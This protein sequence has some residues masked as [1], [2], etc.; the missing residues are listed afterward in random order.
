MEKVTRK[1]AVK[2]G[3]KFYYTGKE[4]KY[5]H[6]D[7]RRLS[8][9]RCLVCEREAGKSRAEYG[10]EWYRKNAKKTIERVKANNERNREK[11]LAYYSAYQKANLRK[12]VER[13]KE[14]MKTDQVFAVKERVRGLIRESLKKSG[15]EKKSRT[16]EILGC[17]TVFFKE[18]IEKQFT[19]GMN[20]ENMGK[21]HIDHIIPMAT[22]QSEEDVL[23]LNHYTNLRPLWASENLRKSDKREFLI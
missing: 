22:A 17:S 11:M 12:I 7:F 5:G 13:R 2:L 15:T 14:R 20:W 1:D 4:C 6:I 23:A 19:K 8:N 21:W 9:N 10:K 16:S 3:L 18:H